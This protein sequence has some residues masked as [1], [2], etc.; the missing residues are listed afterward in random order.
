MDDFSIF[1]DSFEL[2]LQNLEWMLKCCEET[3]LVL[4]W[5]KY[6]FMIQD[7]IVLGHT[8]SYGWIEVDRAK[9]ET[10]DKLPFATSV[11]AIRSFSE[12][13]KFVQEIY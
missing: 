2:Y 6:H 3:N 11:M 13:C 5:G 1:D 10:I 8:I 4:N 9:V 7:G 12:S